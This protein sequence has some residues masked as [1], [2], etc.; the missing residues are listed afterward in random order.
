MVLSHQ[1]AECQPG[2][3]A[4]GRLQPGNTASAAST[5]E[6]GDLYPN[7]SCVSASVCHASRASLLSERLYFGGTRICV[8]QYAVNCQSVLV[9]NTYFCICLCQRDYRPM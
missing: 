2:S 7:A 8:T 6:D 1:R 3:A 9:N 5:S 4:P